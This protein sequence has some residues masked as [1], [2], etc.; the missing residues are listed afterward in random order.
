MMRHHKSGTYSQSHPESI[1]K[2][3][4]DYDIPQLTHLENMLP[5]SGAFLWVTHQDWD[6]ERT[7]RTSPC[8]YPREGHGNA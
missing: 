4:E 3:P 6:S 1:T 7:R 2:K 5:S 8:S